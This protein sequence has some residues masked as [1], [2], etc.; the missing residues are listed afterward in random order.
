MR[1][2]P[3]LLSGIS[4]VKLAD[5]RMV[6]KLC[7]FEILIQCKIDWSIIFHLKLHPVKFPSHPA[8]KLQWVMRV[9]P[10]L[11]SGISPV[12]LA[13]VRMVEKLCDFEILYNITNIYIYIY[14]YT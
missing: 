10:L 11:L 8:Y 7:D 2:L 12:K 5:V 9:L 1:V 13:D 3:L 14:T 4:P 6:E